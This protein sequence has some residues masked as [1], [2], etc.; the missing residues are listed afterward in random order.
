VYFASRALFHAR[1]H[2]RH[3]NTFHA[4][5]PQRFTGETKLNDM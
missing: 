2:G 1:F 4:A 5:V 3:S